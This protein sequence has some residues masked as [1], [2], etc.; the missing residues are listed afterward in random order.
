MAFSPM[1]NRTKFYVILKDPS[2][3][4]VDNFICV[5]ITGHEVREAT[6]GYKSLKD[7]LAMLSEYREKHFIVN[8]IKEFDFKLTAYKLTEDPEIF[9]EPYIEQP[10]TQSEASQENI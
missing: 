1:R 6:A 8:S 2:I 5:A 9:G 7:T 4:K 10:E 3:D